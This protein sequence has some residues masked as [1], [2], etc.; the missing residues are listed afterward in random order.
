M[1]ILAQSLK[2]LDSQTLARTTNGGNS[3]VKLAGIEGEIDVEKLKR[4]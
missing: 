3:F 1:W 4:T 2:D